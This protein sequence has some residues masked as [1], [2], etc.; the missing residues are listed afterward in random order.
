M[1]QATWMQSPQLRTRTSRHSGPFKSRIQ[2]LISDTPIFKQSFRLSFSSYY[3][4]FITPF[5][6]SHLLVFSSSH[7]FLY[8]FRP[9]LKRLFHQ[10][11]YIRF[12]SFANRHTSHT[13][14]AHTHAYQSVIDLSVC[15]HRCSA[16]FVNILGMKHQVPGYGHKT[17]CMLVLCSVTDFHVTDRHS[18]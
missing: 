8:Q 18:V 17:G 7:S 6:C 11:P 5:L 15:V 4:N 9:I 12:P 13:N 2:M 14:H 16:L 1:G 3:E 10:N